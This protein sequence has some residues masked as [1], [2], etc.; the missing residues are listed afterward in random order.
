MICIFGLS[1][2]TLP[3]GTNIQFH[4]LK[5]M[6]VFQAGNYFFNST[7]RFKGSGEC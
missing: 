5:D 4:I 2:M 1:A 7:R 6:V 3:D